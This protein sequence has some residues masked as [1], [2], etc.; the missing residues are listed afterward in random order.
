MSDLSPD[1]LPTSP[2]IRGTGSVS[3]L[4]PRLLRQNLVY[5]LG[6]G[7]VTIFFL[8]A[9]LQYRQIVIGRA[10]PVDPG[11]AI[12]LTLWRTQSLGFLG[13][14]LV[15]MSQYVKR[16][17]LT[18][19][20]IRRVGFFRT[21]EIAF[22]VVDRC[23]LVPNNN[24]RE[25]TLVVESKGGASIRVPIQME[26]A[27]ARA[28]VISFLLELESR[29]LRLENLVK[30]HKSILERNWQPVPEWNQ[31]IIA[32]LGTEIYRCPYEAGYLEK[33][34][35]IDLRWV[36][37]LP[38][39]P[40]PVG[41]LGMK[42][43]D[44]HRGAISVSCAACLILIILLNRNRKATP[45]SEFVLGENGIGFMKGNTLIEAY[46]YADLKSLK[47]GFVRYSGS[48]HCSLQI[49]FLSG[50]VMEFDLET[51]GEGDR[52]VLKEASERVKAMN[53][54]SP[55]HLS[56]ADAPAKVDSGEVS[57]GESH[58]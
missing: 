52:E 26:G 40:L 48:P 6:F 51:G 47:F 25:W 10:V 13:T 27:K 20:S 3:V 11:E 9:H 33:F 17:E 22:S 46:P 30:F 55:Q 35:E 56:Q 49:K 39:V 23:I 53:S 18:L 31:R 34:K 4:G 29:G 15:L 45:S 41:Y 21:K 14:F 57:S 8:L 36:D 12:A 54:A 16:V 32:A 50:E 37:L 24:R 43:L 19:G 2:Y 44:W 1:L 7:L 42:F 5:I 38:L 58:R 28:K